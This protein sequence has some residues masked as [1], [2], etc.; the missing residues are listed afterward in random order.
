MS[1]TRIVA[2]TS[3]ILLG[4][5]LGLFKISPADETTSEQL[6]FT[7]GVVV[8]RDG[9]VFSGRI[10]NVA[11]GY[12]VEW[13][14][15]YAIVP[16]GKVDVTAPSLNEAFIAL[17]DRVLKPTADDHLSLA[18]WCLK[19]NLVG[20]AKSE[21]S[22]ALQLEPLRQESRSLMVTI[23][24]R[25]NP[26]AEKF[27]RATGPAMTADGFLRSQAK[28]SAG[29]SRE[30]HRDYVRQIQPLLLN[31]CGNAHCHGQATETTFRLGRIQRGISGNQLLSQSNL[32]QVLSQL[33][34]A[35]PSQSPLLMKAVAVDAQHRKIFLG[36]R[37]GNQFK[38]LSDWVSRVA[39]DLPSAKK[40]PSRT[41]AQHTTSQ[42]IQLTGAE[43][44]AEAPRDEVRENILLQEVRQQSLPDPFDP[45][46]FNRRVHGV[47]ARELNGRAA[48]KKIDSAEK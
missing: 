45:D 16:F 35:K 25:L 19:N 39:G 33:D 5:W 9:R 17:R 23:D 2:V 22:K 48:P 14:G 8:L 18:E 21:V 38:I 43:V 44:V 11:G 27:E 41:N 26:K 29:L 10:S 30:V 1:K 3:I 31:K 7:N 34:L 13:R 6:E 47:S 32:D 28:T 4:L 20:S 37:G 42:Q 12:R 40:H 15:T 46:V 36:P 24:E